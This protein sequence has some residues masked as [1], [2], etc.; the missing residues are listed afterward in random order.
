MEELQ[1]EIIMALKGLR[2]QKKLT[3]R[4]LAKRI[5]ISS[6]AICHVEKAY[7]LPTL[8]TLYRIAKATGTKIKVEFIN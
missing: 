7:R 3:Q 8:R 2:L 6:Q 4:A 5:G 1:F